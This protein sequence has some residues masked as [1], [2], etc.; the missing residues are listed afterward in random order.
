MP[1]EAYRRGRIWWARGTV[2]YNGRPIT[3][4]IRESTGASEESGANDWITEREDR[5]RRVYLIGEEARQLTFNDALLL[6]NPTSQMA[7]A[8]IPIAAEF[9]EMLVKHI[10]PALVRDLGPKLYPKNCTD[11]WR[12][13]VIT[14]TRAVINNGHDLKGALCPPI[15]IKGYSEDERIA[16]DKKRK[17]ASRIERRPGD[18]EWLLR[19]RE[20]AAPRPAALALLMY[21]TG[22]RVGQA[23]RMHPAKHLDLQNNRICIPGAKGHEDRWITIPVE[24]VVE[25]ANLKP[26][27]PRGWDRTDKRNLRVFGYASSCGPLKAW[28][29]ACEAAKIDYRSP[30]AA[31]RHGFGQEFNVRQPVDEKAAGQFGGWKDLALMKRTYTH[32]EDAGGKILAAFRTGL[33]HAE[34]ATGLKLMK[35]GS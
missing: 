30:H 20:H 27:T 19:F 32:A 14:P 9:G 31:G 10:T 22:A 13:W 23:V 6:Y 3:G 8:L 25:L 17:K 15:K 35:S 18:W 5:E 34:K 24:L 26:K 1:L 21:V 28:H 16:Q 29:S 2:D 7:L 12:R 4:Y 11:Y 33:E